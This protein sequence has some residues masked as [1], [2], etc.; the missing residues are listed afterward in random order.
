[1]IG[2]YKTEVINHQGPWKS[3]AQIEWETLKWVSWYNEK[4]LH[5][6]INYQTPN[7][8]ESQ[9]FQNLNKADTAA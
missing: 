4:R 5:S 7:Q 9:Y 6:A 3:L 1:V 8:K 2:L